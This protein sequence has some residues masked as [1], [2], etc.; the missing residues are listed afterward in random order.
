MRKHAYRF[1]ESSVYSV[2]AF[3]ALTVKQAYHMHTKCVN[4]FYA[5]ETHMKRICVKNVYAIYGFDTHLRRI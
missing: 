4:F 1:T 2:Y 5:Y 3:D